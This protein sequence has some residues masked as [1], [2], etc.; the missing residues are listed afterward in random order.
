MRINGLIM[1]MIRM[2]LKKMRNQ[3]IRHQQPTK[4]QQMKSEEKKILEAIMTMK[5]EGIMGV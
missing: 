5:I 2:L 4:T 1:A 3:T